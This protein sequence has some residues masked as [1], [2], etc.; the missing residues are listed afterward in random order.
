MSQ[1]AEAQL[2]T[3]IT[4]PRAPGWWGMAILI[5]TDAMVFANLIVAYFTLRFRAPVWP[6]DGT[7]KPDLLVP[8][9]A[10]IILV[11]SSVP[12]D[13]ADR[14]IRHGNV[15]GLKL[16]LAISFAM[17]TTFLGLQ[18]VGAL[19]WP[20]T[21][22]SSQ[23]SSIFITL[24]SFHA[25][26]VFVALIMNLVLQLLAWLGYFTAQRHLGVGTIAL[27]W[28]FVDIIWVLVFSTLHL[29]PYSPIY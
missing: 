27:F 28:H 13:W 23:Y 17:G 22:S 9:I 14:S 7:P 24:T 18:T 25:A 26:H 21:L 15:R 4:G 6:P 1:R 16:G 8:G 3:E 19:H 11:L 20:F 12:M 10:T 2:P 29:S 5:T